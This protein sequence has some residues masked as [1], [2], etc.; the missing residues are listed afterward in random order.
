MKYIVLIAALF[1]SGT[2]SHLLV[3][4]DISNFEYYEISQTCGVSGFDHTYITVLDHLTE[5]DNKRVSSIKSATACLYQQFQSVSS[6]TSFSCL[7]YP[8]NTTQITESADMIISYIIGFKSLR[9]P[10]L[11]I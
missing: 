5:T 9:A 1:I 8:Q 11:F 3:A 6:K 2:F 7:N 10:P 4:R